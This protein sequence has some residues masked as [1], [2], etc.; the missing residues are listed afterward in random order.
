ML[1]MF[2]LFL[3]LVSMPLSLF[4]VVKVVQEYERAVIFRLGRL[5]TGGARGPGVFFI[6]PCLDVY[7]KIDM[8]TAT[9]DVPPQ[10]ILTKDSVT[11][12]VNAIMYYKV[13]DPTSAV[14]NVD[15][16][17]GSAQ[18][19]AATTLRNVLGTK[20]LGDILADREAIAHEMQSGLDEATDSWGVLV[21]RVEVKDVRVPENLQ[22]AMAAE[23]EAARNARAKVIAAEGEHKACRS[24]RL[25]AEVIADCPSALQLRY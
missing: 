8:R 13:R 2:S 3:V 17:A 25:A 6:I 18:L 23:A 24:L 12:F 10:E 5:V 7:E 1:T 15:D 22:R 19:L 9:Y 20:N 21:E 11:V 14:A 4:C 16:Y